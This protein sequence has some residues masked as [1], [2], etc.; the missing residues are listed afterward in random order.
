MAITASKLTATAATTAIKHKKEMSKAIAKVKAK[1]RMKRI[2]M[3]VPVG[4]AVAGWWFEKQAYNEWLEENPEGSRSKYVCE[5]AEI[6][7][8]IFDEWVATF[9]DY[10]LQRVYAAENLIPEYEEA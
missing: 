7:A 9:P 2:V 8:E 3:A 6:T 10:I 5:Q 4:G 1:A